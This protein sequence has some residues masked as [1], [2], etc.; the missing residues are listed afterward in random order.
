[1]GSPGAHRLTLVILLV[2]NCLLFAQSRYGQTSGARPG[3]FLGRTLLKRDV[4]AYNSSDLSWN[5]NG[6]GYGD[7]CFPRVIPL[8]EQCTHVKTVCPDS[9]TFLSIQ[10]LE[11][12]FC[13]SLAIRPFI[14]VGLLLWLVFLFSTLGIS[15][16]DFF[17]PNLATIAQ[18]LGLDE[19]VAGVTF[20]AFGNGSP[21]MFSTYSAMR[22]NSG[23]L[24]IG[25]LLGAAS[26]IVSCVVGS[27][28]IIKPFQVERYP[29]LR[30]VGF[31]TIAVTLLI[32]ILHDGTLRAWE[33]GCLVGLYIAY[34]TLVVIGTWWE[35]RRAHR[36]MKE[37][38]IRSEYR[39][40]EI[41]QMPY[42]DEQ[43][44][45]DDPSPSPERSTNSLSVP[46]F[47]R[48]RAIS[49]PGPP[50]LGLHTDLP[51]RSQSRSQ[52]PSPRL[53]QMPSFSLIGALEFRQ[54]V[55][56]LQH[57]AASPSLNIFEN[58]VTPYVGGRYY[59]QPRSRPRTPL[60]TPILLDHDHETNPWDSALGMPLNERS[61][62]LNGRGMYSDTSLPLPDGAQSPVPVISHTP[63][64]PTSEADTESQH[65]GPP[66]GR[67]RIWHILG[68]AYHI[69]FPTLHHFRSKTFIGKVAA[70]FAAPAVMA[71]TVTLP[72]IVTPYEDSHTQEKALASDSRLLD[73]EE[74]GIERT[75]IAEE[76]VQEEMHELKFNKWLM[77]AQCVC[78]PLFCVGVLFNG[79][80]QQ[81]WLLMAAGVAGLACAALVAVFADRGEHPTARLTRCMMGFFVA[82]VWIMAIADEVVNVLRTF[83]FIFGL[84]D[85]II[86]LTIFAVGNS[87]ADLVANMSVAVFAPIMGFSACFG[88]PMLNMLLGV[89][90][91]G[92]Y[93]INQR[94]RPYDLHFSK[95]LL[96]SSGGLLAML[97]STLVFVPWNGFYLTRRWGIFLILFYTTIMATNIIV[98]TRS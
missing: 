22:S 71:L 44:Y 83:G 49:Q 67:E 59:S 80:D 38:L 51:Q 6:D 53:S 98:E 5:F 3:N 91:S 28:C 42:Y 24:A 57:Q 2:V 18:L 97:V 12:Y 84:S 10:Y 90:V 70:L 33:A 16:S 85:A 92:S 9:D 72:V 68:R 17:C 26:F 61:P 88:G 7:Q 81:L 30:D 41:P 76:E 63:A 60:R 69:L 47:T 15:A 14:F 19:N 21:D 4:A 79:A 86:G 89:G 87:L 77:A 46:T 23:S 93:I 54:V 73:F 37:A 45:R 1:M 75:L 34:V 43:P 94:Q 40:D 95:T 39:E 20:L 13:S 82:V 96:V 32:V 25:E 78:A 31:F 48:P 64:S 56:S 55:S 11:S 8:E 65:R 50:R 66:I 58:P 36:R 35:R 29:F 74:E 27:M 52:S 62:E